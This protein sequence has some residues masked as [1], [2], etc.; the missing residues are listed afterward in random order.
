MLSQVKELINFIEFIG[1]EGQS[2]KGMTKQKYMEVMTSAETSTSVVTNFNQVSAHN[3][4][5]LV[6]FFKW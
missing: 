5:V 3:Q 6:L 1:L 2:P 4:R